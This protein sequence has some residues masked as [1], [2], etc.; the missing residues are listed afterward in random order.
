MSQVLDQQARHEPRWHGG[1]RT[2]L[3]ELALVYSLAHTMCTDVPSELTLAFLKPRLLL[4][5]LTPLRV[6]TSAPHYP[7]LV[8]SSD[9]FQVLRI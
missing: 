6:L 7:S 1:P 5:L 3:E 2:H 9:L 4:L 8:R